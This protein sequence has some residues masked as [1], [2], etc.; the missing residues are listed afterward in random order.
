MNIPA[1]RILR[2]LWEYPA[3]VDA[4]FAAIGKMDIHPDHVKTRDTQSPAFG[5]LPP[6]PQAQRTEGIN[7]IADASRYSPKKNQ[8]DGID[9]IRQE[10]YTEQVA[11]A[12]ALIGKE[13][14][15]SSGKSN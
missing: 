5:K 10:L 14:Q 9:K 13:E 3:M 15:Q 11:V 6:S 1:I 2:G 8:M 7:N 12:P 4:M